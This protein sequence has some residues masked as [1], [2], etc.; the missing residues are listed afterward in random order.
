MSSPQGREWGNHSGDDPPLSP[1]PK[2]PNINGLTDAQNQ[3]THL[4]GATHPVMTMSLKTLF[5]LHDLDNHPSSESHLA[6]R[7]QIAATSTLVYQDLCSISA[8]ALELINPIIAQYVILLDKIQT[9]LEGRPDELELMR[10]KEETTGCLDRFKDDNGVRTRR[11]VDKILITGSHFNITQPTQ[12]HYN[13]THAAGWVR[14]LSGYDFWR[15]PLAPLLICICSFDVSKLE[16]VDQSRVS[17]ASPSPLCT[18]GAVRFASL[19]LQFLDHHDDRSTQRIIQ[20]EG[21]SD[22]PVE[23]PTRVNLLSTRQLSVYA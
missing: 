1:A 19:K 7:A 16:S 5:L 3:E 13:A 21:S 9:H 18:R 2:V 22:L 23:T 11:G 20:N 14:A 4:N 12:N 17:W 15:V 8:Q 6:L 10:L